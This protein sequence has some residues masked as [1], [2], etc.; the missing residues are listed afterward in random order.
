MSVKGHAG[1]RGNEIADRKANM[2]AY[3]GRVMNRENRITPAGIRQDHPIH[4]ELEHLLW[5][6]KQVKALTYI[7]TDKSPT[8]RWLAVIGRSVEHTY[9]CGG[10]QN[11]VHLR[12]C[13]LIGDG[14]GRSIEECWKDREWCMAVADFLQ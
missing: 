10:I 1:V 13:H 12:R 11:A 3:G 7:V 2:R 8:K 4:S 9:Q 14:K 5:S 6:R